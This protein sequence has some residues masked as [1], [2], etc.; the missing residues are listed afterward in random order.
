MTSI[1]GKEYIMAARLGAVQLLYQMQ[2]TGV[3][4]KRALL[5][6][7]DYFTGKDLDGINFN[8]ANL[9]LLTKIVEGYD[10]RKEDVDGI[11]SS[12]SKY[13]MDRLEIILQC[14]LRAGV[15][16]LLEN[17][18]EYTKPNIISSYLDVTNAFY[19]KK[20][21]GIVNVILDKIAKSI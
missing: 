6:K 5:D 9:D 17:T 7:D 15:Y 21:I 4:A 2:T 10:N 20:E 11:I 1:I 8:P 3:S 18:S 16:E 12:V 13:E 19:D 14:I